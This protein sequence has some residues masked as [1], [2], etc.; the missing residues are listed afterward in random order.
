MTVL[1]G[2]NMAVTGEETVFGFQ[3]HTERTLEDM[4]A[5]NTD[6]AVMRVD[7]NDRWWGFYQLYGHTPARFPNDSFTFVCAPENTGSIAYSGTA[8]CQSIEIVNDI[9]NGRYVQSVVTFLSHGA[10]SASQT[11]PTDTSNPCPLSVKNTFPK[12][13]STSYDD[14]NVDFM[15]LRILAKGMENNWYVTAASNGAVMHEDGDIDAEAEFRLLTEDS[16]DFPTIGDSDIYYHY[17]T[18]TTYWQMTWMRVAGILPWQ[19]NRQQPGLV[20]ATVKLAFTGFSCTQQ[21]S[22]INPATANKWPGA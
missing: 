12:F 2:K 9:R 10:L 8:K 20:G 18:S 15:R 3:I 4:V 16:S 19:G 13:G 22:I 14:D 5:G 11:A 7:G 1:R 21:G 6:G 17:V